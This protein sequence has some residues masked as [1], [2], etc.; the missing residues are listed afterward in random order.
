MA[1]TNKRQAM[2]F[3][4]I[5]VVSHEGFANLKMDDFIKIMPASRTTVYRYFKSRE[6]VIAAVVDEYIAYINENI[7]DKNDAEQNWIKAFENQ[8][9][10]DIVFETNIGPQFFNDLKSEFIDLS[11]RLQTAL[12]ERE[13]HIKTFYAKGQAVGAYNSGDINLWILQDQ[14]MIPKIV[15]PSYLISHGTT[16]SNALIGYVSM[17]AQQVLQPKLLSDFN[18]EFI[19]P[20]IIKIANKYVAGT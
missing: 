15:A 2:L 10:T 20:T 9:E 18:S 6:D 14:L 4:L 1:Q 17:K 8:I 13:N 7:S 3:A 16:I 11:V 5:D 19:E 12:Q